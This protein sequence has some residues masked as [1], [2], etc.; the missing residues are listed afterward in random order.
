[1]HAVLI[2]AQ[3]A[4]EVKQGMLISRLGKNAPAGRHITLDAQAAVDTEVAVLH[5]ATAFQ[6]ASHQVFFFQPC[7]AA[8]VA[9]VR[10]GRL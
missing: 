7:R 3:T 4:S 5:K 10:S 8:R 1:M 6:P 9:V 2:R